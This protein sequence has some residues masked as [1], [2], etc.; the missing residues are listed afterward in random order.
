MN[1]KDKLALAKVSVSVSDGGLFRGTADEQAGKYVWT[2]LAGGV[3]LPR[4]K[5]LLQRFKPSGIVL[6]RRNLESLQ[7]AKLLISQI[8]MLVP[9]CVV[10]IDEEGGRVARL[11]WPVPR[12]LTALQFGEMGKPEWAESQFLLQSF[13][14]KGIGVNCILAP[15]ADVLSEETN[16]ALAE[17]CYSRNADEVSRYVASAVAT[18]ENEGIF[19]CVKHF[20][21]HGNTT[22]DTHFEGVATDATLEVLRQREWPPFVAAFRAGTKMCMTCHVKVT[23]IDNVN[24]ATLSTKILQGVL[25]D[26]LGFKGLVLSDDMRMKAIALHFGFKDTV[27]AASATNSVSGLV[28]QQISGFMPAAAEAALRAG[29]DILLCCQ[30]IIVEEEVLSH[31]ARSMEMNPDFSNILREKEKYFQF[32][33]VF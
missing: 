5:E 18:L 20:P 15:V 3:L 23:E 19:S 12:G 10:A 25:R 28:S 21:G 14:S 11:P 29:C 32:A 16:P 2:G 24:P 1:S 13:V 30:S 6:F 9:G 7:Q 4:E 33:G 27:T 22:A 8:R 26:E 31:I 17:R